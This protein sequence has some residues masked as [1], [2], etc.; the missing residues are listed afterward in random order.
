MKIRKGDTVIVISGPDKGAKGKV[1]EAYPKRD[2][3]LVE[4]VNRIKKHVANSAPERGAESGGI[5]TQEAPIHVSNV[6]V[7]D[8][9]GNPT[10]IGYRFDENGKKIRVSKRNGK[11]I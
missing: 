9:D 6:M 7:V 1:I 5:V 11:D 8:S 10:R 4:G 2:K 3:V